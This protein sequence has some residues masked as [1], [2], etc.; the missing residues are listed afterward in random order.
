M[1]GG[2]GD[3]AQWD[4]VLEQLGERLAGIGDIELARYRPVIASL[5]ALCHGID[6]SHDELKSITHDLR[7]TF[8]YADALDGARGFDETGIGVFTDIHQQFA[9]LISQTAED[10][11]RIA[12]DYQLDVAGR[13]GAKGKQAFTAQHRAAKAGLACAASAIQDLVNVKGQFPVRLDYAYKL[14]GDYNA[15][16]KHRFVKAEE[17]EEEK[18]KELIRIYEEGGAPRP[19]YVKIKLI[20]GNPLLTDL[21]LNIQDALP[22]YQERMVRD[23]KTRK[24]RNIREISSYAV[25]EAAEM[26]TSMADPQLLAYVREPRTFFQRIGSIAER[27]ARVSERLEPLQQEL[28][29]AVLTHFNIVKLGEQQ[30]AKLLNSE[31]R[32]VVRGLKRLKEADFEAI[33]QKESEYLPENRRE[34]DHFKLRDQL[35]GG[36]YGT[37]QE[38][39]KLGTDDGGD[40][41]DARDRL[42]K[43]AVLKAVDLKKR[44]G[45]ILTTTTERGLDRDKRT[46]NEYYVGRQHG[47]GEF[48]FKREPAPRVKLEDVIGASF[49]RAKTHLNE[50]IETAQYPHVLRLSAPGGKVKSN[51]LLIGPYGCG[52]TE[53]ARAVCADER[54]IG[55]SVSVTSTLTAFVHESVNNVKRVYDSAKKLHLDARELK[56]VV[57]ALDEFDGWFANDEAGGMYTA[58]DMQ[59][60]ENVLLEVL[61]GMEDY[62]GIV[63]MAMTNRPGAIPKGILRR[64][65]YV[66]VVGQL[67]PE[68][69]AG[70]LKMYLEKSLPVKAEVGKEYERWA[71]LFDDAP[72][73]VIRKAVD[74]LH[75]QLVPE[76]IRAHPREAARLERI[77]TRREHKRGTNDD[78]DITYLR[79]RLRNY[80]EITTADVDNTIKYLLQ[81]P[82]I[83]MQIEKAREVYANAKELLDDISSGGQKGFGLKSRDKLYGS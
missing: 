8:R 2:T 27:F 67:T 70:M 78:K 10:Y 34:K 1:G 28:L 6:E 47:F 75:F 17:T 11:L 41:D 76:Y 5:E 69:R 18:Q 37:I 65:R 71:K 56:P 36:V 59:Q 30:L 61:D 3:D 44:I 63:T 66:D 20:E 68:E 22:T 53:L 54:V 9:D 81:Q 80:R 51:I 60:I 26:L 45:D 48:V 33:V 25:N 7:E 31:N 55:A 49:T 14:I 83:R 15:Y 24:Q 73:D 64:F 62:N 12:K 16:L 29:T 23:P 58:I 38:L 77:L 43:D 82:P 4:Q 79:E 13:L 42:A 39:A 40:A 52:K 46:D 74:E 19:P 35:L 50:I 57:L 72:G 21:L 32:K